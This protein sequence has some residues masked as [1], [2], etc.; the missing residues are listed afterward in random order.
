MMLA[1]RLR[2]ALGSDSVFAATEDVIMYEYDYGLDR[3]MPDL[4]ALP[5]STAEVQL[6]VR[7]AQSAGVPIVARGA[8]TGIAGGS[9]P[10]RGGLVISMARMNQV[11][12]IDQANRCAVVQPGVINLDL[13]KLAEPYGLF[14]APDPSSQKASTIGG[15]VANN[16]GG[17]HC[18]SLGATV[19][20]ILGLEVVL[21]D[22]SIVRVGGKSPDG[23][24]LDL[25]G[26]MVGSE[27]TLGVVTESTVRLLPLPEAVRTTL[28]LFASV[29]AASEAVSGL[30]GRGIV[31]SALEMMDKLAL[32]AIEAAFHAGYPPEAGAVLLVEVDGLLE[33]V[34]AQAA[35]VD[36]V[37]RANGA[38]E[39]R[40][41]ASA[42]DRARLWA[43]RKGAASAMGRIA[44][45][46]YLHDA[47]VPRT[48]LPRILGYVVEI[49]QRYDLPIANLFHAG[50][51]N[52]H[53][54]ILFDVREAGILDR[55]LAAGHE[56]LTRCIEVGGTITGEHGVG[57]EKPAFM[58]LIFSAD[59]L[60]VMAKVRGAIDPSG[61]LNPAKVLP[62]ASTDVAVAQ[63]TK[64]PSARIPEGMWV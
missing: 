55:V 46:Y 14:F 44:P 53:P 22:G 1:E 26:L 45:N 38:L 13:S 64:Q 43:A 52:L 9:V 29:E 37:C 7:E 54:M 5:R 56:I 41:A 27:G 48:R 17:P 12:E 58:P 61:R 42:E 60:S 2:A 47:V 3:A 20:H 6:L 4:V 59:D 40:L 21:Y 62:T 34:D 32:S 50:D 51:G 8:G 10:A 31:P 63:A 23:P 49:G 30:I 25:T 39:I 36:E 33:Q 35:V 15:N 24:G 19:N 16:A 18:L 57:M 11:L 28:A